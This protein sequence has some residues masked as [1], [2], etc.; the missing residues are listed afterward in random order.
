MLVTV[1]LFIARPEHVERM[2]P[3]YGET[4]EALAA[5]LGEYDDTVFLDPEGRLCVREGE[6]PD[7][8]ECE[9]ITGGELD[10]LLEHYGVSNRDLHLLRGRMIVETSWSPQDVV[11][12]G[13]RL[14]LFGDPDLKPLD[15][16]DEARWDR[17]LHDVLRALREVDPERIS[18]TSADAYEHQANAIHVRLMG[19]EELSPALIEG[20]LLAGFGRASKDD[21]A[22]ITQLIK[23]AF[24][25]HS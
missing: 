6:R 9:E 15:P 14:F 1:S 21:A 16:E 25:E 11:V 19:G 3:R 8:L 7:Y 5:R 22:R 24:G 4:L 20:A 12:D 17:E 10:Q 13:S 18:S 2:L 23:A